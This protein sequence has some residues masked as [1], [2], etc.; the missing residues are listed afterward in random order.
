[1]PRRT[2]M[3]DPNAGTD[4]PRLRVL[5]QWNGDGRS[6]SKNTRHEKAFMSADPLDEIRPFGSVLFRGPYLWGPSSVARAEARPFAFHTLTGSP[7][8]LAPSSRTVCSTG[9]GSTTH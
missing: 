5:L 9:E 2:R 7:A 4:R 8:G 1:V 3:T 6:L